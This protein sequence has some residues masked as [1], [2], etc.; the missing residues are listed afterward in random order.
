MSEIYATNKQ[1]ERVALRSGCII[2]GHWGQYGASRLLREADDVLGTTFYADTL[3]EIERAIADAD[4]AD[5]FGMANETPLGIMVDELIGCEI[6]S[7]AA[8]EAEQAL[9]DATVGGRW[10]WSDGEFFLIDLSEEAAEQ[11]ET[12]KMLGC[13]ACPVC[14]SFECAGC[15]SGRPMGSVGSSHKLNCDREWIG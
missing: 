9:N 8:D 11:D 13:V 4:P 2:D 14:E 12:C 6:T 5:K 3:S 7:E 15:V 1:G 10:E